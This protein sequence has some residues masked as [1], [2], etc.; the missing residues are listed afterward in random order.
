MVAPQSPRPSK[1]G[2][3]SLLHNPRLGDWITITRDGRVLVRSGKV[4]LGQGIT[5]ALA[6][7]VAEELD[8][9]LRRVTLQPAHTG[10]SPDEG[11]TS[12]SMS[13]Q[14]SGDALR[15]VCARVRAIYLAEAS[16]ELGR[17]PDELTVVDGEIRADYGGYVSYWSLA[18]DRLLDVDI[19]EAPAAGVKGSAD[20]R[21]VGQ[22][23][24]RVDGA[25]KIFGRPSYIHDLRFPG[26]LFGRVV[27]PPARVARL[28][29]VD[30]AALR[31][32]AG[33]VDVVRDGS[34]LAVI[35]D[36][37]AVAVAACAELAEACRWTV[38]D[39]LPDQSA[40]TEYLLSAPSM[41]ETMYE[42]E[43]PTAGAAARTLTRRFTRGYVEHASL[44]PSCGVALWT[45]DELHVWSHSQGIY[46]LRQELAREFAIPADR[47]VVTFAEGA[48]CYG[49]NA[50]DDAAFDA[51]LLAAHVPG[52]H[53]QVVWSRHDEHAW[54]PFGP[55]MVTEIQVAVD[56]AAWVTAWRQDVW[57]NG[58]VTRP[59][60]EG[61]PPLLSA[62]YRAEPLAAVAASEPPFQTGGGLSRNSVPLYDFPAVTAVAHRLTEMPL[63]TSALRALG[64]HLNV[65]AIESVIDELAHEA[66]QDPIDYR[67]TL[68][69]DERAKAV[70][71][72]VADRSGWRRPLASGGDV[73]RGVGFAR[74]KN[75]GGYC[76]VVAE[77]EAEAELRVTKLTLAADVGLVVNPD[78]VTNQL[79]GGAI[80]AVS[81]TTLEQVHFDRAQ[82]TS[83]DWETYP[84]LRFEQVPAVDVV[85][86]NRPELPTL[87]SGE[88]TAGP[89]AAAIGNA[90]ADALG[91]RV[92][93]LPLTPD[94]IVAA[95]P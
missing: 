87:G 77:V 19:A 62:Q 81:W 61:L 49:H 79:E 4:E 68:L 43:S 37:E 59:S 66:G 47:V 12:G 14:H 48:G 69:T 17:R 11:L 42:R 86:L 83:Q 36:D 75:A 5:T 67:L 85:L 24:P 64:A 21:V 89:T 44:A 9:D 30:D 60:S 25:G 95:M 93:S 74:Y 71:E 73:G 55:A 18:D 3:P 6:Q 23:A 90:L 8:V 70:L 56:D 72:A 7:I 58:H 41:T 94:A 1:R 46:R 91:V 2:T 54:E 52:R 92:R 10:T 88:M 33:V 51:A 15:E 31:S 53:V 39:S 22:S 80:Q 27:R 50:A 29:S 82:V 40:L 26:Q 63:R 28:E 38:A 34:F 45:N 57:S 32:R 13:V 16:E 78:G 65:Y 84:I 76:A 20:Y 35:A